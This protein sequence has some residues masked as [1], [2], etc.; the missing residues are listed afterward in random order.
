MRLSGEPLFRSY[1]K[2]NLQLNLVLVVILV[3]D[4]KA[5]Y[6][7]EGVAP[8]LSCQTRFLS[9]LLSQSLALQI[10]QIKPTL[11]KCLFYRSFV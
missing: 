9:F 6:G 1:T 2:K 8:R 4:S 11:I 10:H 3:I 7:K 5:L